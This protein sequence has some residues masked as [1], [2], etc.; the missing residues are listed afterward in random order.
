MIVIN[1]QDHLS[2]ETEVFA[3]SFAARLDSHI[4]V[5][6]GVV[7]IL[8]EEWRLGQITNLEEFREKAYTIHSLFGDLQALN[9]VDSDG[10][11]RA[12]T[13]L[14]GNKEALGLDLKLLDPTSQTLAQAKRTGETQVTPP[15]TLAQGGHGFVAY[16]PLARGGET[17]GFL[18]LVFRTEPLVQKTVGPKIL[19]SHTVTIA[20]AGKLI[21]SSGDRP[22]NTSVLAEK[23]LNIGGRL[24]TIQVAPTAAYYARSLSNI[25]S[26]VAFAGVILAALIAFLTYLATSRQA[27]L[28][29]SENRF[30]NFATA[31]SDWFWEMGPNLRFTWFS[32]EIEKVTGVSRNVL[33]NRKRSEVPGS[34]SDTTNWDEHFETLRNRAPFRNF[35]YKVKLSDREQWLRTSGVPVFDERGEFKGYRGTGADITAEVQAREAADQA[36]VM[37]AEAVEG[38]GE[39]FI[40]WDADDRLLVGNQ[41]FRDLNSDISD[42]TIPGAH[43]EEFLR[44]KL[45][46]NHIPEAVGREEEW[47]TPFMANHKNPTKEIEVSRSNGIVL[48]IREHKLK[49]GSTVTIGLDITERRRNERALQESEE[50]YQLAVQQA[51]IWDWDL[52]QDTLFVSPG[53]RENLGYSEDEFAG[54]LEGASITKLLHPNDYASYRTALTHHLKNPDI[55]FSHE[56]RYLSK[57]G[58]YRWFL[59][60]GQCNVDASGK[61]IRS[62]GFL[63]DITQRKSLEAKLQQAQKMEAIGKLTGGI[64][65]DFNN[66]LAIIQGNAELL[67]GA[68]DKLPAM[69]ATIIR[70]SERGAEL[71][72]RL[73]AFSRQQPLNPKVFNLNTLVLNMRELLVHAL[74]ATIEIETIAPDT[75]W[76]TMADPGQVENALVNLAINARDA[77]PEGGALRI[78]ITNST[79]EEGLPNTPADIAAGDY[80]VLSVIDQGHGMS[81]EV[82]EHAFEPFFTTKGVGQ[83]SGLGLS[84]VLGFAQQSGG[85][86]TIDSEEGKG[87]TVKIFLP[88]AYGK[89]NSKKTAHVEAVQKGQG[90]TILVIEDDIDV[91]KMTEVILKNLNY[92]V[93]TAST[94]ADARSLIESRK[95]IDLV[96]TDVVLPGRTSGPKFAEELAKT[97]SDLKVVFMSGYPSDSARLDDTPGAKNMLLNKPFKVAQLAK[98]LREAFKKTL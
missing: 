34:D 40:L 10:V 2:A 24:W 53:F 92:Q 29:E 17:F 58:E 94:I 78:E 20:D 91:R 66:L 12:V 43:F 4:Q 46:N 69:T 19:K 56:H 98:F 52:V 35:E 23:T 73:L 1:K 8:R 67:E 93:I 3:S 41:K 68:G 57:T 38:L 30:L 37:L 71:T 45:A 36:N 76:N 61:P 32:D 49:N 25:D 26:Y 86:A 15:F 28:R 70:A 85:Q 31:S 84:M 39:L 22:Q 48:Q 7:E 5:R 16:I 90:E 27:S 59:A 55:A 96:L 82:L 83:G 88:R 50:R 64:A 72:Q 62:T 54:L 74:G 44:A 9:W 89:N 97:H 51:P 33:L 11:I 80:V 63:T 75:L 42:Y 14:E 18:N 95:L 47:L 60:R 77:M 87:T 13:P 6:L 79:L 81:A 65:H 21:F